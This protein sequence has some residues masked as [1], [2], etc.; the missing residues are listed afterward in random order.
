MIP[1]AFIQELLDRTDIVE[2]VSAH[3]RLKK[4]GANY[5]G[6]CPF[7]GEKTPSFTV[8]PSKQFY[9]CF[10]CGAHGSAIGFLMEHVG[11][12][13]VEAIESLAQQQGL[14]V[15]RE[16]DGQPKEAIDE[17]KALLESM[18]KAANF[19][20]ERL[21]GADRAIQ[22]LRLRGLDGR[23]A[24]R[25]AL[26][27]A[28]SGWHAL[29]ACFAEYRSPLLVTAGLVIERSA[30]AEAAEQP[31]GKRDQRECW[32]RFR[33]RIMFPIRNPRGQ[34]IGFGGRVIDQGEPKYLNSP[35]TPLFSKGRELYGL[36]ESRDG[37]RR[38]NQV[39]VVE[40][41]MD[42]VMLAHHGVD[43]AVATLGT[44]TS[45]EHL[46]KL[47]KL[48]DRVVFCFDGDAAGRRAAWKALNTALPHAVDGKRFE[49]LF[50]PA[51]HDP[52]S[53]VRL[54][55]VQ[56]VAK[57]LESTEPLSA[58]LM[59]ELLSLHGQDS[60]ED[61]SSLLAAAIPLVAQL[62]LAALRMQLSR[63]LAERVR[64]SVNELNQLLQQ[65]LA[66]QAKRHQSYRDVLVQTQPEARADG[67]LP[68]SVR[69]GDLEA[70]RGASGAQG[71]RSQRASSY[72]LRQPQLIAPRHEAIG[73]TEKAIVLLL[74]FPAITLRDRS[75]LE[76]FWPDI[77]VEAIRLDRSGADQE[78]AD[79]AGMSLRLDK[80]CARDPERWTPWRQR[81]SRAMAWAMLI[82]GQAASS[83][84][85]GALLQ[86]ADQ[87][88]RELIDQVVREGLETTA[89][90]SRYEDLM[91]QRRA[92]RA[93]E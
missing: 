29:E 8:S 9:H 86:L 88:I 43:F 6:L 28:P 54:E 7:H 11:M 56:G 87:R 16:R 52:D 15:P 39:L 85:Q 41:Y 57:A 22:Y 84:Y 17:R 60:A 44:A 83:E 10:G 78:E 30:D 65:Q 2:V 1:Q 18:T 69:P 74:R 80:L 48:V 51:E 4:A 93:G 38:E 61:R 89:S 77:V 27:Y 26:G 13:Y 21:K 53:F 70:S 91:A 23:S 66:K 72:G 79:L 64:I 59:R 42:V 35:E 24:A 19:Y 31:Q 14:T 76:M 90:R 12:G 55:G 5:S 36:F 68:A 71:A 73:L 92:I 20:R 46:A 3:L 75:A 50:L 33:D 40:G 47:L 82:D 25:F 67:S 62:P 32:D 49:F 58:F 81:L 37:L 63:E 45:S 34:V